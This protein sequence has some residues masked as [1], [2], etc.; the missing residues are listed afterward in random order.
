MPRARKGRET[1]RGVVA[2]TIRQK[3]TQIRDATYNE[4]GAP[5]PK[6]EPKVKEKTGKLTI[7]PYRPRTVAAPRRRRP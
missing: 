4:N 7:N 2:E 5:P 6:D 1:T 3:L